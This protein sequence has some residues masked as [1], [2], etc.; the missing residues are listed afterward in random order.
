MALAFVTLAVGTVGGVPPPKSPHLV[1]TGDDALRLARADCRT[2]PEGDRPFVRYLWAR[3]GDVA[4]LR[5]LSFAVNVVSRASVVVRPHPLGKGDLLVVRLDLRAYAPREADLKEWLTLWE[6]FQFDPDFSLLITKG[7]LKFATAQFPSWKGRGWVSRW[8]STKKD[9]KTVWWRSNQVEEFSFGTLKD[10]ELVRTPSPELDPSAFL[11]L[12]SLTGS[13][14]PVVSADYFLVR[15]LSTIKDRGVYALVYG[16]LYYDFA[17]VRKADNAKATDED[18]LLESLGVGSVAAGVTARK[19]FERLRGDQRVA[20]FRSQV[21]GSPRQVELFHHLAVAP[22]V[23][24]PLVSFTHDLRNQDVD[25]DVHPVANLLDFKDAARE[26]IWVRANGLHGYALFNG[27]G[28]RQDEVPPDVA[29]DHT[30]PPPHTA[31]LQAALSCIACHEAEGSDGWKSVTNDV[32]KLLG[33][34]HGRP[35]V[36]GDLSRLGQTVPDTVDRLAGLYRGDFGRA[37][38][39]SRDD[40]ALAVLKA[41]G[42]WPGS[43]RAQAD[44][45]QL[46]A[47]KVVGLAR[48]Y[49]HD[50]VTPER[51]LL[52]LGVNARGHD[53]AA[54]LGRLLRPDPDG[55]VG[56]PE[57]GVV[58]VP[59]DPRLAALRA[60]LGVG[61]FDWGF[62]RAFAAARVRQNLSKENR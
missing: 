18:L 34:R 48:A 9:G 49:V 11:E 62:T 22:D 26:V 61:R 24:A 38:A 28:A 39:R 41:T 10:V 53:G 30:I 7:S 27:Q 37:L 57:A 36:F 3:G 54:L 58:V 19:L 12:A 4:T 60:G 16:G 17:G 56:V 5:A 2:L 42:P 45:V 29:R 52:E 40:Y 14:A 25:V 15:V 47:Q 32:Q 44:A 23:G 21:T 8:K 6:E 55:A 46:T 31:R 1:P 35:D 20:T 51:A 50:L 33:P 43:N 13:Q 59:E